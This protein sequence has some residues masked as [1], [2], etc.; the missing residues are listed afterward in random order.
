VATENA[1]VSRSYMLFPGSS[2]NL[3]EWNNSLENSREDWKLILKDTKTVFIGEILANPL[4]SEE[5]KL[6]DNEAFGNFSKKL[7]EYFD[8]ISNTNKKN[9]DEGL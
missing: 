1:I 6:I 9:V 4:N 5:Y 3:T 7:K 8:E 2:K